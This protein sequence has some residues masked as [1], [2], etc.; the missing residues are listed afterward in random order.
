M[1]ARGGGG[2]V[3]NGR[4][5]AKDGR[6]NVKGSKRRRQR[7]VA[8][9]RLNAEDGTGSVKRG[10]RR[11]KRGVANGKLNAEDEREWSVSAIHVPGQAWFVP[12]AHTITGPGLHSSTSPICVDTTYRRPP[13]TLSAFVTV[14]R[15]RND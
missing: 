2:G 14:K 11:R 9:G 12:V 7:D 8:N 10:K 13:N 15:P 5:N 1:R 4:M 3:A 6:G